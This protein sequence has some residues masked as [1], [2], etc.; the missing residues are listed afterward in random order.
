MMIIHGLPA[1][2]APAH[3]LPWHS[4]SFSRGNL[5]SQGHQPAHKVMHVATHMLPC[6]HGALLHEA[7]CARREQVTSGGIS[8]AQGQFLVMTIQNGNKPR[9]RGTISRCTLKP[10]HPL[11]PAAMGS[12]I[13][14]SASGGPFLD[15][16]ASIPKNQ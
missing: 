15:S 3:L 5:H 13:Q 14:P 1:A 7:G 4:A 8:S 10:V 12:R 11:K 2:A 9:H 16:E 6:L